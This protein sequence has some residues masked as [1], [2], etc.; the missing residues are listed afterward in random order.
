MEFYHIIRLKIKLIIENYIIIV[1]CSSN[2][3][4]IKIEK[5]IIL[6]L[7]RIKWILV[8]LIIDFWIKKIKKLWIN[9]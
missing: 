8:L 2:N 3:N 6:N 9:Y 7:N 4:G 5:T 1:K